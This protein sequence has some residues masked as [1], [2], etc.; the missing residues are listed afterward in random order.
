M[1][2]GAE[3]RDGDGIAGAARTGARKS[4][5]RCEKA[6]A[7]AHEKIIAVS[8]SLLA[9][10]VLVEIAYPTRSS[11]FQ[12]IDGMDTITPE[13]ERSAWGLPRN[14][15]SP[16]ASFAWSRFI[17]AGRFDIELPVVE[18]RRVGAGSSV[19]RRSGAAAHGVDR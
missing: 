11:E 10:R 5:G 8:T 7:E 17:H 16:A 15:T 18:T 14:R 12:R 9:R 19:N 2:V 6:A 13:S 1:S 3:T 4:S